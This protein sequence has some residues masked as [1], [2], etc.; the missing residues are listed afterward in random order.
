MSRVN[1]TPLTDE[2]R[3]LAG[4]Q[5]HVRCALA[6]ATPFRRQW[7]WLAEDIDSAAMVGLVEAARSYDPALGLKFVTLL[8]HR[9]PGAIRDYIR[10]TVPGFGRGANRNPTGRLVR[11][12]FSGWRGELGNEEPSDD[13]EPVGWETVAEAGVEEL[14]KG[15][16]RR[17]KRMVRAYFTRAGAT[18][19]ALG[20]EMGVSETR[21]LQIVSK[22]L[23]MLR[24]K[25]TT[26]GVPV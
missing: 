23:A 9:V 2:Q 8:R 21:V 12:S 11:M 7:P 1:R 25:F 6:L 26:E 15:L 13:C 17:Y 18:Y 5:R 19:A 16:P 20:A 10:D 14:T 4:D 22:S 24:E 3:D